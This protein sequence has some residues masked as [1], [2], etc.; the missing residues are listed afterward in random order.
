MK[1][2]EVGPCCCERFFRAQ[3]CAA[4][5]CWLEADFGAAIHIQCMAYLVSA[6]RSGEAP[7]L[8]IWDE[9]AAAW[10]DPGVVAIRQPSPPPSSST[11]PPPPPAARA[12][13]PAPPPP[14]A[15]VPTAAAPPRAAARASRQ[16]Q[17]VQADQLVVHWE[18]P[19]D[20]M[21]PCEGTPYNELSVNEGE[22][23][24]TNLVYNDDGSASIDVVLPAM[25]GFNRM[26]FD[27]NGY[28]QNAAVG[29]EG[30]GGISLGSDAQR[31]QTGCP[32]MS[33]TSATIHDDIVQGDWMGGPAL[34]LTFGD[35]FD[36]DMGVPA[37]TKERAD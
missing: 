34:R 1:G 17:A 8:Q 6:A 18:Q 28:N 33:G 29:W 12:P 14:P 37:T 7:A 23:G 2:L 3:A 13:P 11:P 5:E 30:L 25:N 32:R 10:V 27:I 26:H 22:V 4:G 16:L 31:C 36:P 21:N 9:M 15:A 19:N 35:Q 24:L 20:V